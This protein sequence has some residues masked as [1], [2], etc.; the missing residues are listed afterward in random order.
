[1]PSSHNAPPAT[2]DYALEVGP[3]EWQAPG[4]SQLLTALVMP[5]PVGWISTISRSGVRNL[6]PYSYFNLMG[7]DPPMSRS[8]RPALRTASKNLRDVPEFVANIVAMHLLERMNFTSG[9]F[10]CDEDEFG[11]ARLTPA[12]SA[13]V[14]AVSRRQR[15]RHISNAK[16]HRSSPTATPTSCSAVSFTPMSISRCG[17][18]AASTQDCSIRCAVYRAQVMPRW[19]FW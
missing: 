16:S 17:G 3:A 12:P 15:P 1:M 9:D 18:T 2:L 14:R 7:S 19:A 6:A 4:F 13:K 10:P 5:R 8:A 11:W